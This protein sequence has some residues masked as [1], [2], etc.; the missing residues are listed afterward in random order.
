MS[1]SP[2]LI[3]P[4]LQPSRTDALPIFL[5][6]TGSLSLV[7]HPLFWQDLLCP[8]FLLILSSP[9]VY[10]NERVKAYTSAIP[11]LLVTTPAEKDD[12]MVNYLMFP[13]IIFNS[14]NT[15]D[16]ED[17]DTCNRLAALRSP[18]QRTSMEMSPLSPSEI[19]DHLLM[20]DDE[21]LTSRSDIFKPKTPLFYDYGF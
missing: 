13:S 15:T 16:E 12:L 18:Q 10:V 19:G 21:D 3:N 11:E 14:P 1:F 20:L 8:D 17:N 2:P 9:N 4:V 6:T 7:P 5:A